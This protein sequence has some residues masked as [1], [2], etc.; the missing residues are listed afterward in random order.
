MTQLNSF[1]AAATLTSGSAVYRIFRLD[2]LEK[3][4]ISQAARLPFSIRI[5][6]EN[7]LRLEDGRKVSAADIE[8]VATGNAGAKEISF[9]PARVLLQDFTGVPCAVDLASMRDAL[10]AMGADARRANPLLAADLVIDHSVQVDNYARPDALE[11][12]S[13]IEYQRNRERYSFLRWAQTAFRN[14]RVVPPA[15]GIVHQVNLEHLAPVVYRDG[16][17]AYP[18]TVVGTDSHT[19]M[20]NGLGVVGWG[21]GGIEAEAV[22]LGQPLYML[23]PEVIGFALTGQ[24]QPGV[25]ATDLV[26]TVTQ[27]LR[28]VGVV[29][30]FVEFFGPGVSRMSLADRA[31]IANMAPEYGA[32]IGFFPVDDETLRYLSATGRSKDE[33]ALVE[34][35]YKEQGMFRTDAT[36]PATFTKTVSLDLSSVEPSLAGPKRPQDR[37]ALSAMKKTWQ[38]ALRAPVTERGFGLD[39]AALSKKVNYKPEASA[40]DSHKPEAQAKESS[41]T[42]N[43]R[44]ATEITH[45]AVVIAAITSCTNTSNPSV[46]LAAGLLAKKA[47]ERGLT[48]PPYVKTSLAPGSRVVTDYLDKSG[49]T[50]SLNQLGFQTVGYGCTTCIGNSGPLPDPVAAAVNE[51]NLVASAVISG[52]RNFEGRVNPLVKAN[53]LASPPLVVAYAIAG[54]T[55]IDLSS[56]PIGQGKNGPVYLKDIWP[57]REEVQQAV[58]QSVLPQMFVSRYAGAFDSNPMWN[59]IKVAE[60]DLYQWDE[61]STY[62]QEPPFLAELTVDIQP[63]QPIR[64]ARVLAMVGDSVTTDHISPAGNIAKNSPAGKY[65][66]EHGVQPLDFNS[67]GSRRGN[68]RVMLRGTFANIRI[69]NFLA[70]GTEGGVTKFLGAP[71]AAVG[72]V[73]NLSKEGQV[74][75]LSHVATQGSTVSNHSG[76]SAGAEMASEG[77]GSDPAAG[78]PARID[79]GEIV[80]IYDAAMDYKALRVPTIILA[81]AEYG[82][83]SSRDW[84]AKG[85]ML[86]GVRAVIATS[87]ERIHRSNLVNMG[88]LPL[89]F[90]EGQTWKT[91]GLTGEETYEILGLDDTLA[92]R[93]T[94]TIRAARRDGSVKE[95]PAHVRIDTPVELD[96]YKNGGI[97]QTVVRKLLAS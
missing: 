67:Y 32:T 5:L 71:P 28:N 88:V 19:T 1:G 39:D 89:Q 21:V 57:T 4:G 26:L 6:L 95:F 87:F 11:L 18:D 43:G 33:V 92:P 84:A 15:T 56:E 41:A 13:L 97:L 31:T 35:Y 65:L 29:D 51:G 94:V 74:E 23:L 10:Q 79:V 38:T 86:L 78:L 50:Q 73:S 14:F 66:M 34:R 81:G 60:G 63:I 82:T 24:L 96:Y 7:L 69:R 42:T 76:V 25:T 16:G 83:G 68:D 46:M 58:S 9:M 22:M 52:N 20:I 40:R 85:T 91:L 27:I 72:Q 45:G 2:A 36:P 61:K 47:I 49:L 59:Q 62:I 54:T 12:N 8:A 80:P 17:Q 75:N 64:G 93:S 55:D 3:R 37:V 30:K 44:G 48:V 77:G 70:P 53:F 90:P